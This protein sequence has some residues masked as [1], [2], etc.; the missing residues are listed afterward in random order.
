MTGA[1]VFAL[2][3]AALF[4]IGVYGVVAQPGYLRR[5]LAFNVA[6]SGVFLF[7]GGLSARGGAGAEAVPQALIITGVVVALAATALALTLMIRLD[8]MR[9]D[10]E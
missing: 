3:G 6:G 10:G 2:T 7:F 8:E 1:I 9:R 4:G 5:I